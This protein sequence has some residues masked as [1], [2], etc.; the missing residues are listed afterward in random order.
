MTVSAKPQCLHSPSGLF[1]FFGTKIAVI[2]QIFL[3]AEK[4]SLMRIRGERDKTSLGIRGPPNSCTAHFAVWYGALSRLDRRGL[5]FEEVGRG[6]GAL[7][8]G[9]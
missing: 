9:D 3:P 8:S 1:H 5:A 7:L 4:V 6:H 2:S